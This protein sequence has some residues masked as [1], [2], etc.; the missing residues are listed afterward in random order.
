[1][2]CC[3]CRQLHPQLLVRLGQKPVLLLA[4]RVANGGRRRTNHHETPAVLHKVFNEKEEMQWHGTETEKHVCRVQGG[5]EKGPFP[6][7]KLQAKCLPFPIP[8]YPVAM[9][10]HQEQALTPAHALRQQEVQ[11]SRRERALS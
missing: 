10:A 9:P 11:Q 1:M 2:L 5:T 4:E 6:K 8:I 7:D 3:K